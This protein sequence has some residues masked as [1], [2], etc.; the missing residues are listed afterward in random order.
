MSIEIKNQE[1]IDKMRVAGQLAAS[2]L[3]MIRPRI[4]EVRKAYGGGREVR[5]NHMAKKLCGVVMIIQN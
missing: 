1:A 4:R 3:D 5:G 2:V